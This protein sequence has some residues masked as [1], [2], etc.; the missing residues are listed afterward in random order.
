MCFRHN[1]R[2]TV[3]FI[4]SPCLLEIYF[5]GFM[6]KLCNISDSLYNNPVEGRGWEYRRTKIGHMWIFV[7]AG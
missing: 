5:E 2:I 7:E 1:N 6:K 4:K 3:M